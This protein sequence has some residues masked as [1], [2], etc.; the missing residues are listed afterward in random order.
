MDL[1]TRDADMAFAELICADAQ[2]LRQ[3]FDALI[4][5][6]FASPPPLRRPRRHG[7]RRTAAT[8]ARHAGVGHGS[9]PRQ[10]PPR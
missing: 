4:S 1:A 6:S 8:R 3:E 7:S 9:V 10:S 2:W 5:S